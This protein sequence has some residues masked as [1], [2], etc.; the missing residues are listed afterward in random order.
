M[1]PQTNTS[2]LAS[3][4]I[5]ELCV[6]ADWA[7]TTGDFRTLRHI[8]EELAVHFPEPMHCELREV[9]DACVA[10]PQRATARWPVLRDRLLG[11]GGP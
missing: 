3:H 9:A 8:A 1:T 10:D 7:W 5:G 2:P 4:A 11:I 6:E